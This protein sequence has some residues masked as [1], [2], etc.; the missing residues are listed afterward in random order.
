MTFTLHPLNGAAQHSYPPESLLPAYTTSKGS[1]PWGL[2]QWSW[3][4]YK[5]QGDLTRTIYS[6]YRPDQSKTT[7]DPSR[8]T[9]PTTPNPSR[10]IPSSTK[11]SDSPW[12]GL[13][14]RSTHLN[15][16]Q[17]TD[18]HR[19]RCK[20]WHHEKSPASL[21]N[22]QNL[23][24][25][26]R[27]GSSILPSLIKHRLQLLYLQ[28]KQPVDQRHLGDTLSKHTGRRLHRLRTMGP[29]HSL[30]RPRPTINLRISST[31]QPPS[32]NLWEKTTRTLGSSNCTTI[33]G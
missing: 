15:R 23:G 24:W 7:R 28:R 20:L 12:H 19:G 31:Q 33:L 14:P 8:S 6:I 17:R 22:S 1:D 4:S 2:G 5:G 9:A 27:S 13:N 29:S 3:T 26:T 11:S 10:R 30:G 16:R 32:P 25:T 21:T 18:C